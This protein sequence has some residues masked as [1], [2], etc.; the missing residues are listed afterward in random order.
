MRLRRLPLPRL[1]ALDLDPKAPA[2]PQ[3]LAAALKEAGVDAEV[4]D[5]K[6]WMGE[7][8]R[9]GTAV[10]VFALFACPLTGSAAG[11]VE[12]VSFI[13]LS[14]LVRREIVKCLRRGPLNTF[15]GLG[16]KCRHGHSRFRP[17]AGVKR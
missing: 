4:D 8:E 11:A 17:R 15:S 12:V 13:C 5:H 2:S 16:L 1:V 10:R 3:A 9:A 6:R 14:M 7:V